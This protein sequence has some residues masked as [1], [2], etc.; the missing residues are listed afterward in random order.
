MTHL[1]FLTKY[2]PAESIGEQLDR[3]RKQVEHIT[4]LALHPD[5][6]ETRLRAQACISTGQRYPLT[7]PYQSL[8]ARR[9]RIPNRDGE[10]TE[11][12]ST[13]PGP[14]NA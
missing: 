5:N 4:F 1:Q 7:R 14:A 10:E 3:V 12:P 13:A 6:T 9:T 2:L 8:A 11:E